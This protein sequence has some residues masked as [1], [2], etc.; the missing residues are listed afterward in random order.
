MDFSNFYFR[1]LER[2]H[3][4]AL[5]RTLA[6][7]RRLISKIAL[8]VALKRQLQYYRQSSKAIEVSLPHTSLQERETIAR[9]SY[10]ATIEQFFHY[11]Q[12]LSPQCMQSE[13]ERSKEYCVRGT[14][15]LDNV[16][17][18]TSGAV[19]VSCH[20]GRF[21]DI[22]LALA[23]RA[24]GRQIIILRGYSSPWRSAIL[25]NISQLTSTKFNDLEILDRRT[26][27]AAHRKLQEGAFLATMVDYHYA[28]TRSCQCDFFG[29]PIN[30]PVGMAILASRAHVPLI[31]VVT[32][33]DSSSG[34]R[35]VELCGNINVSSGKHGPEGAINECLH[36]FETRIRNFPGQW[37]HWPLLPELWVSNE[38]K[39]EEEHLRKN[40]F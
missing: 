27:L 3:G 10:E 26:G 12:L 18:S 17:S 5:L 35:V 39:S 28:N 15:F 33:L 4:A 8:F 23:P 13:L 22:L 24:M 16:L 7:A 29:Q 37:L 11:S 1:L 6:A 32:Y 2:K 34:S 31:P 38:I 36:F 14:Q 21:Y 9:S 30:V 25:G 19:F 20:L 40:Q